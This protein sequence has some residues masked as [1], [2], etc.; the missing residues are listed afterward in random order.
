MLSF[1]G[2][3]IASNVVQATSA[4]LIEKGFV[5]H[6]YLG[7][8]WDSVTPAIADRYNLG[9]QWGVYVTDVSDGS[10]AAAAGLQVG[11]IIT[12]VGGV[13]LDDT[14]AF[15]NTLWAHAVGESVSLTVV[16]DGQTQTLTASLVERPRS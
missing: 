4:Q 5:S 7:I 15:I 8:A 1:L 10:P 11:D 2:F 9:A 6:P 12:A 14:H 3:A 13:S 16:R